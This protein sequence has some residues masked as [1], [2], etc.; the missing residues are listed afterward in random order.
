METLR[1]L[2]SRKSVR[3]YTGEK[4]TEEELG[5][6]LKAGYAAPVGM[7]QYNTLQITVIEDKEILS[8]IEEAGARLFNKP[9][10]H[11]LYGAPTFILIS[12]KGN[13][14]MDLS[15]A[16]CVVE[17]MALAAVDLGVG[18]VHI[19][20]AV[21]GLNKDPELVRRLNLPDGFIPACGIAVG[22]TDVV[23]EERDIPERIGTAYLR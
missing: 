22:K 12:A 5:I 20:G 18:T 3:S 8:S 17:N 9:G 13:S 10:I 7:A 15:N 4:V 19:W 14:T 16:S 11:P 23:Y 21:A 1:T 6:I 2:F